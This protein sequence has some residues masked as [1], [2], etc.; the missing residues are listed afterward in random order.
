VNLVARPK[1]AA[2]TQPG[3]PLWQKPAVA[4]NL[5]AIAVA[6]NAAVVA[7]SQPGGAGKPATGRI[8]ALDIKTGQQ[9][10]QQPLPAKPVDW[11]VAIDRDGCV[12]VALGD[13]RVLC[14]GQD[15]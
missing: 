12:L 13:G 10:W 11:G 1:D 2:S 9:L 3:A 15:K 8:E 5:Q 14:F 4:P 6:R 7:W